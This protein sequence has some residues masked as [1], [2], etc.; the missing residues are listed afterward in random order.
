M[1]LEKDIYDKIMKLY[2]Q[3]E[4]NEEKCEYEK[5]FNKYE[6][7]FNMIPGDVEE[8]DISSLILVS[9]GDIRFL[10]ENYSDAKNYYFDAMNCTDGIANPYIL[11]NLGKCFYLQN[12]FQRAKEYFIRTYMIDGMNLFCDD[13]KKY[14]KLIE[15][16]ATI[17]SNGNS[18]EEIEEKV[19]ENKKTV[20][21]KASENR[22]AIKEMEDKFFKYKFE[23][24][25]LFE[26]GDVEGALKLLCK[27]WHWFPEPKVQQ[28]LFYLLIE[29]FIEICTEA[30]KFDL[31]NKYI[32]LL[33]VTGLKRVDD[34]KRE[35]IAGKLAY[36]QGEMELAKQ[37]FYIADAKSEGALFRGKENKKYKEFIR[38]K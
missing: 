18:L 10:E 7:A 34:G 9:M 38:K 30:K 2:K 11:F 26:E 27:V 16:L 25:D 17:D 24:M 20:K 22:K 35:F 1:E 23:Y 21:N 37:L 36:E 15:E 29:D 13:N 19:A 3:G 8:Y 33:F 5:A 6:K 12:D 4:K 28:D 14:F 31:A 32:S